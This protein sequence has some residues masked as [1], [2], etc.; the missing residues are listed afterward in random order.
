MIDDS[1]LLR[2]RPSDW[3]VRVLSNELGLLVDGVLLLRVLRRGVVG[4]HSR[5][6]PRH[7]ELSLRRELLAYEL[8]LLSGCIHGGQVNHESLLPAL[9]ANASD[10][11]PYH[12][13]HSE[14]DQEDGPARESGCRVRRVVVVVCVVVRI[15]RV[16]VV[17]V[18]GVVVVRRLATGV[19]V[20]AVGARAV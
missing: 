16:V 7:H 3:L 18:I 20:V 1:L 15:V 19:V 8:L 10:N 14:D 6:L 12:K 11:E 2:S 9:H 17:R 4:R 13:E 5:G